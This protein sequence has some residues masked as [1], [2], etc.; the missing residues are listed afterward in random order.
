MKEN[1]P[2]QLN[3]EI[4]SIIGYERL[5]SVTSFGRV[6]SH[7]RECICGKG[8][9]QRFGGKFRKKCKDRGGYYLVTLSE[10]SKVKTYKVHRLVAQHYIRNSLNL[11][12][13][14]H[15]DGNKQNNHIDNLE[16]CTNQENHNHAMINRLIKKETSKFHGVY[17]KFER[18]RK[19]WW[20][21][22]VRFNKKRR[23]IGRFLT[24]IEAAKAYNKYVLENKLNRP[25]NE[26]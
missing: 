25:L 18:W 14:N 2:L 12:E 20:I 22:C 17:F 21:A 7:N 19:Q 13:V 1:I 3:E 15:K 26:V 8:S 23:D 24:E 16:W 11:P 9:V 6:W 10:N 5:Y 4:K